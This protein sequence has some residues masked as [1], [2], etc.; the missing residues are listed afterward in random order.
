MVRFDTYIY[1]LHFFILMPLLLYI[2]ATR[3]G[4]PCISIPCVVR[5][6]S[7]GISLPWI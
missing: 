1:A 7:C 4:N 5:G 2:G 6:G 3:I